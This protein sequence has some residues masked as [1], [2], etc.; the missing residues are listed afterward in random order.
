MTTPEMW[1]M[2][3]QTT[4]ELCPRPVGCNPQCRADDRDVSAVQDAF[5]FCAC[6]QENIQA[7][8]AFRLGCD[9]S[10][11]CPELRDALSGWADA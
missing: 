8:K 5:V 4:R 7:D 6:S 10:G 2:R 9:Q 3:H 1:C 11:G